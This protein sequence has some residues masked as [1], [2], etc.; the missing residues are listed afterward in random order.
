MQEYEKK[1]LVMFYLFCD[2]I[3]I[4]SDYFSAEAYL[5]LFFSFWIWQNGNGDAEKSVVT[6]K[7]ASEIYG[8]EVGQEVSS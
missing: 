8:D 3:F 1:K 4:H 2:F 5:N 6:E 7:S